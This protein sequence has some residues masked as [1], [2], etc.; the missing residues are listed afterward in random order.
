[1]F[2]SVNAVDVQQEG[3]DMDNLE[4]DDRF[5]VDQS[6]NVDP[7]VV[8]RGAQTI[9]EACSRLGLSHGSFTSDAR[10]WREMRE[11][12][13]EERLSERGVL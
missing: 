3:W 1:M 4:N 9:D 12:A 5:A 10:L 8:A 13:I 6:A 11:E 7:D 2:D